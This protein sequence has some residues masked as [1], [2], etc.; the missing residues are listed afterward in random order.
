MKPRDV[1]TA[2]KTRSSSDAIDRLYRS[3]PMI[4]R[5]TSRSTG[6]LV[7]AIVTIGLSIAAMA[8][9]TWTAERFPAVSWLSLFRRSVTPAER[10]VIREQTTSREQPEDVIA[11]KVIPSLGT[12]LRRRS[13]DVRPPSDY[14]G[15][16]TLLTSDGV[17][18][19][20][21]S[22]VPDELALSARFANGVSQEVATAAT[23]PVTGL[24]LVRV[25]GSSSALAMADLDR[26]DSRAD[27]YVVKFDP[28]AGVSTVRVRLVSRRDQSLVSSQLDALVESSETISRR[29]RLDR[30]LTTAWEGAALVDQTGQLVGVV[31][32]AGQSDGALV[33]PVAWLKNQLAR[34]GRGDGITRSVLGVNYVDLAFAVVEA[35][36]PNKG[37]YLVNRDAPRQPAVIARSPAAAAGLR[38]HDV[39]I[40]VDDVPVNELRGLAEVLAGYEAGT[41]VTLAVRRA[42]REL[43]LKVRLG[44]S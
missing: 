41:E 4:S 26:L 2:P 33:M 9:L 36:V 23:D 38:T 40:A 13:S 20:V 18:V 29:L 10:V 43:T 6:R 31:Q 27:Y 35:K 11:A 32:R 8:G 14:F 19:T 21:S 12:L 7:S 24:K 34:F 1:P 42:E 44:D 30:A 16:V 28:A 3:E 5:P 15:S 25:N 39:I 17:G 22:A 37:A